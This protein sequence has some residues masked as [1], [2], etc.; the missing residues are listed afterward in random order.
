MGLLFLLGVGP[1]VAG[2]EDPM[3][4]A[5]LQAG[6]QVDGQR[7]RSDLPTALA[8][9]ALRGGAQRVRGS[10]S[11]DQSHVRGRTHSESAVLMLTRR[12]RCLPAGQVC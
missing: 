6:R 5:G 12:H 2:C 1:A 4:W 3:D 8:A 10:H 7:L 9:R 11:D